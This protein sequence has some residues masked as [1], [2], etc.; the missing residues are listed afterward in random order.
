MALVI[1]N[2]AA[3]Q[4]PPLPRAK[5]EQGKAAAPAQP[6]EPAPPAAPPMEAFAA[7]PE[8]QPAAAAPAE[9]SVCQLR[10]KDEIADIE[11]QPP[12]VGPGD[13][14]ATDVVRLNAIILRDKSRVPVTPPAT[15][16]CS[17]AEAL[18]HWVRD[19]VTAAVAG[20]GSAVRSLD[21]Y[22]SF[23]CRGRNRVAGAKIS[24]HGAANAIDIRGIALANGKFA[25]LTDRSLSKEFRESV[26][27]SACTRFTTVLGPGADG[28]HETHIHL[29]LIQRR[30]GY[31][32]C[33]WDVLEPVPD[34]PVPR[35]RP[36]EAPQAGLE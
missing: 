22:A 27:A 5:P 20:I 17:M 12:L 34:I 19:D 13:C 33:Q 28:H 25:G 8:P 31:R 2:G 10:V 7:D 36:A 26:K 4:T 15:L 18:A 24:E 21:N 29:D 30:G 32:M 23:D 11:A 3:A 6:N 1:R 16:R 35:P 14:G 9:T